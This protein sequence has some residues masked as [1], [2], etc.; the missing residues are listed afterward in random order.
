MPVKQFL[1]VYPKVV[2]RM[3]AVAACQA[4]DDQNQGFGTPIQRRRKAQVVNVLEQLHNAG[5]VHQT[6]GNVLNRRATIPPSF[7]GELFLW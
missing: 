4:V 5:L 6:V 2:C 1:T 7:A 3:P